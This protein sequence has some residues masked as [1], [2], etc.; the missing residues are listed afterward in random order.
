MGDDWGEYEVICLFYLLRTVAGC[1]R[2][3]ACVE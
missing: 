3:S 2:V 1:L